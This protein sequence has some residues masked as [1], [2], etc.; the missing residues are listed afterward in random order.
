MKNIGKKLMMSAMATALV[1]TSVVGLTACGGNN[2]PAKASKP[3][4]KDVFSMAAVSGASFL[5]GN[6]NSAAAALA[7]ETRPEG[8]TDATVDSLK[9]YLGMFS[10]MLANGGFATDTTDPSPQSDGKELSKYKSKIAVEI[11]K[12]EKYSIYYN[13]TAKDGKDV[14]PDYEDDEIETTLEGVMVVEKDGNKEQFNVRGKREVEAED[15]GQEVEITFVTEN[16]NGSVE[17][18]QEIEADEVSYTYT[19]LDKDGEEIYEYEIE[20]ETE[21]DGTEME[22]EIKDIASGTKTEFEVK[23]KSETE[24]VIKHKVKADGNKVKNTIN[25]T[26]NSDTEYEFKYDNGFTETVTLDKAVEE[27]PVGPETEVVA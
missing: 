24:L 18:K 15:D 25:V 4:A 5:G 21:K 27:A 12:G 19:I 26:K 22:V 7:G 2:T 10:D 13:E 17:V 16:E 6:T 8:I 11:K 20:Y 9:E 14:D 3:A 1:A 23:A